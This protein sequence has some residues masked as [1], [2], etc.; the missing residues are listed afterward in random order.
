MLMPHFLA[1]RPTANSIV[2]IGAPKAIKK[3]NKLIQIVPHHIDQQHMENAI[4]FQVQ[5]R[6]AD[7]KIKPNLDENFLFLS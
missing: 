6:P 7:I 4:H 2:I 3:I 5:S 1:L